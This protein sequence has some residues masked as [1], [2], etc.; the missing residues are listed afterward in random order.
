MIESPP[1]AWAEINLSALKENLTLVRKH[2]GQEVMAVIKAGAYGHGLV[3]VAK[4]L[5]REGLPFFGVA[6]VGEA[7]QLHHAGLQTRPYI[8]GATLPAEREEIAARAWT[9]CLCSLEEIAH[10]DRLGATSPIEAHLALDTGMGRGGFLPAQLPEAL[11]RLRSASGIRLTGVGSHLP[12]ADEDPDFTTSQFHRFDHLVN[13]IPQKTTPFHIHL[14]NSAGLLDFSSRTT[15]LVRPGLMLYGLSPIPAWQEKLTPAMTLKT[16]VSLIHSLPAGHGVS[17]GRTILTKDTQAAILGIGY[18]DGYPRLLSEKGTAVLIRGHRC[19]LLGRVTM[20]QIIVDVT[21]LPDCQVGD[22]AILF[23]EDL[24][25][26]ELASAAGT[27]PWE[28]LTQITPRVQRT[29][30]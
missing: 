13:Q 30:R 2:S 9:P 1:R 7:R 18:G 14:A 10:F 6:N 25:V 29:Y 24:L 5:D 17:Y 27:I 20:D 22:E 21:A 3:E 23:G 15:N 4:S 19:P 26:S 11:E 28:F 8:L 12:S 16:R